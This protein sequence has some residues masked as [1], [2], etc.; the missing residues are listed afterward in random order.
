[1]K[2]VRWACVAAA[3]SALCLPAQAE[4]LRCNG[5]ISEVGESKLSILQKCGEPL[6]KDSY[7]KPVHQRTP[8]VPTVPGSTVVAVLPCEQV[9]EWVYDRGPGHLT[10]T[11]KFESGQV[12]SIEYGRRL[13]R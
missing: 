1:M 10:A 12:T 3:A 2:P 8:I 9:D 5:Q 13:Q 7:C 4:S 11:V 6:L